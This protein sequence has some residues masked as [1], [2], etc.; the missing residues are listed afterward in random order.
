M[1]QDAMQE[2]GKYLKRMREVQNISIRE[3]ARRS[4]LDDG[5]LTRLERGERTP[6]PNTLKALATALAVP[7]TDLFA[8]AGYVTPTDL[9]S[10]STYLQICHGELSDEEIAQV[11]AYLR[12][13]IDK[14]GLDVN[15]PVNSTD[16]M[17]EAP[18]Q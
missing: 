8:K 13:L 11:D 3:L 2:F 6:Q 14:H 5:G 1:K 4:G 18:K 10:M 7:L 15:G 17:G 16:E 12:R 9:P